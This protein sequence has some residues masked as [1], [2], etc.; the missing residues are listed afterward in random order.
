MIRVNNRRR[1]IPSQ[2]S[3]FRLSPV[4]E[5]RFDDYK[6]AKSRIT[7]LIDAKRRSGGSAEAAGIARAR[8][9]DNGG[10]PAP[11]PNIWNHLV[12]G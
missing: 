12:A 6:V 1:A 11:C 2:V 4:N 3:N 10:S 8:A 7:K 5:L 9:I